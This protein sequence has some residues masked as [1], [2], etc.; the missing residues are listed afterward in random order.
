MGINPPPTS[1]Q[2]IPDVPAVIVG[3][4]RL[5]YVTDRALATAVYLAT[6]LRKP[7]LL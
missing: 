1:G 5:G 7:I 4:E 3:F 6:R 2:I